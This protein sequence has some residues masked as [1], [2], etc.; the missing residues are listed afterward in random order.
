M[1]PSAQT[2]PNPFQIFSTLRAFQ[3]TAVL[4]TAIDLGIFTA[5]ADGATTAAGIAAKCGASERGVRILCDSLVVSLLLG[6]HDGHYQNTPDTGF[7]LNRHSPAYMGGV[8][9][10][11]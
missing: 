5:I 7:F 10:F 1:S 4:S 3:D 8:K 9:E 6:K 11:L 2:P